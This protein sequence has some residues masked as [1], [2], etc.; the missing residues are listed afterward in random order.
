[1]S[2]K[3]TILISTFV[4]FMCY[5][6]VGHSS[7][8]A[9]P[10]ENL[11]L[12]KAISFHKSLPYDQDIP[13]NTIIHST[14]DFNQVLEH[15]FTTL[16]TNISLKVPS[17]NL[18]DYSHILDQSEGLTSYS[19]KCRSKGSNIYLEIILDYKQA[20][21]LTQALHNDL[22]FSKLSQEDLALLETA[23]K[24]VAKITN[25]N[26]TAY[27]KELA[28][29]DYIINTTSYDYDNLKTDTIPASSYTAAGVLINKVAV[30]QGY[31]EAFKLLLNLCDIECEIVTGTSNNID[32]AWN[33]V[34]L[35]NEW[36]MVDVTY[37]DPITYDKNTRV[38]V[39]NYDYFNITNKELSM[40]HIW[41]TS[42]YP[43]ATASKY[44]Y[45]AYNGI[46]ANNFSEFKQIILSQ[47]KEGKKELICYVK[48]YDPN[49]YDLSFLFKY[50]SSI[51]YTLPSAD[52]TQGSISITLS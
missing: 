25:K 11:S 50:S 42:K 8:K 28:I 32:H 44:N 34:K 5:V 1:M 2:I 37:D 47:V 39:L 27:Q 45:F 36:Y 12:T 19:L 21:K 14:E 38:E 33:V 4:I 7:V 17:S 35:D 15:A 18:N 49:D 24:I 10:L 3:R 51:Y 6:T 31:S 52:A 20:Y 22:A 43:I 29:H 30:C 16:Q 41:D 40:D 48:N 9:L 23:K 46:L 13:K 26:M